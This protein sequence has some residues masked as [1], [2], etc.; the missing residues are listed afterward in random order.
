LSTVLH[1]TL[2]FPG[3]VDFL[4][5]VRF[6]DPWTFLGISW[7]LATVSALASLIPA[8]KAVGVDPVVAL[9]YE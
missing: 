1:G 5:G 6:N 3:F 4:Y 7:L 9:R 2:A 8:L